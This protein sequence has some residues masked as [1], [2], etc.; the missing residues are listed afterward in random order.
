M[1]GAVTISRDITERKRA[2]EAL[3][4]S[5]RRYRTL[6][7]TS[8]DPISLKDAEGRYVMVNP[9]LAR[10][11]R[12]PEEEI[13]GKKPSEIYSAEL[14]AKATESDREVLDQGRIVD[15]E[16]EITTPWGPRVYLGRKAPIWNDGRVVG[17]VAISRDITDRKRSEDALR[18]SELR[19]RQLAEN[20]NE[21]FVIRDVETL[22]PLYVS[23]AVEEFFG[24]SPESFRQDSAKWLDSVVPEDRQRAMATFA[25]P[26]ETGAVE[27]EYRVTDAEGTRRVLHGR[28]FPVRNER[29]EIWRTVGVVEDI[30]ERKGAEEQVRRLALAA[31]TT[32]DGICVTD[33]AG[34]IEFVNS[35]LESLLGYEPGVLLGS[36]ASDLYPDGS[37]NHVAK[38]IMRALKAGES[39]AGEVEMQGKNGDRISILENATPMRDDTGELVGFVCTNTDIRKRKRAEDE[40]HRYS[41]RLVQ[42]QETERRHIAR[43]LH[44]EIGQSLTGLN[45]VLTQL[46]RQAGNKRKLLLTE[47]KGVVKELTGRVRE[48]ALDLRPSMLDDL[49]LLPTL[50]WYLERYTVQT[51]I[52]VGFDHF[53]LDRRFQPDTEIAAYRIVQEALT[54]AARH[55]GVGDVAARLWTDEDAINIQVEDGGKGFDVKSTLAR[56]RTSGLAGMRERA[57]SVGGQLR[58]ESALDSGC[59]ITAELPWGRMGV[60]DG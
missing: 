11:L 32:G 33:V 24:I 26:G 7:E 59:R 40:L 54:N 49:G 31:A 35:A 38:D 30:T 23:P 60:T 48:L 37:D 41:R 43:E 14:A 50:I 36:P 25:T 52:E 53:G 29:G 21:V 3:R 47:A 28:R 39:W 19:F 45:L 56:S 12:L 46:E 17:I 57:A 6:V 27:L 18:E 51:A 34:T 15:T 42:I 1:V 2:E 58:I 13:H 22:R 4:E 55:A 44:D 9:A 10:I 16:H 20:V 5:E 8:D